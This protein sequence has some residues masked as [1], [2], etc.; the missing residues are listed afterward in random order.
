MQ[1]TMDNNCPTEFVIMSVNKNLVQRIDNFSHKAL[2]K[3]ISMKIEGLKL[4]SRNNNWLHSIYFTCQV[5]FYITKMFGDCN[6]LFKKL[7][8]TTDLNVQISC[9]SSFYLF[10]R[11]TAHDD[12]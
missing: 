8:I 2:K 10:G 12:E 11:T 6:H 1:C 9:L 3:F 4:F 7:P 5:R